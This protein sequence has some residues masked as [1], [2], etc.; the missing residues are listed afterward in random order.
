MRPLYPL[1]CLLMAFSRPAL[2]Q[3]KNPD[4][5]T[6]LT[7]ADADTLDAAWQYDTGSAEAILN[8]YEPLFWFKGSS[9]TKLVPLLAS[10]VP[11]RANGLIS[12]DG[13][14]YT[15]PI[16]KAVHFQDGSLMT[17][18][19]VRYSL[20]RFML[21]DR[22]GGPASLL[23]QPLVGYNS[24]RDASG[25]LKPNAYRDAARAVQVKGDAVVLRLPKPYAPLLSILAQWGLV[26]SRS[27]AAQHGDW[28]G[29]EATWQKFNN[30]EKQA[31]AFYEQADGTG[32]FKLERWDRANHEIVLERFDD[33]WRG[34][35]KLKRAIIKSVPEFGTRKLLL[36]AG[37]ADVIYASELQYKEVA[38]LP[39]VRIIE[40]QSSVEMNPVVYFT[41]KINPVGNP[42][43]GSGRL[44]GDGIPPDF[45]SDKNVRLGFA[46]SMASAGFIRDVLRGHG[47]QATGCIP[48]TLP[49]HNPRQKTFHLDLAAAKEHFQKAWDGKV[50]K[51]GFRFTI[52]YNQGNNEREVIAEILKRNVEGLN[53]K[54]HVDV[55]PVE[56]PQF[57]DG[58]NASKLPIFTMGWHAD[59][60]D[61]HDFAFPNMHSQGS[62]P[63][64]Q[65]YS[66]PKADRLI[67][68]AIASTKA[69]RRRKLYFELQRIEHE[70]CPHLLIVDAV[71][72][73]TQ[74]DW[75][76]GWTN[77][78][79]FPDDPYGSYFYQLWK[80]PAAKRERR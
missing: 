43:I 7:I 25:K 56:W 63:L 75:V 9:L 39:G 8:I 44:D 61:P 64:A 10:K 12:R 33:Y 71:H 31:T 55:R 38:G 36:Q 65:H 69:A 60:P 28:D 66:N 80:A 46:D 40:N 1:V 57:L 19:D 26:V 20:M 67:D 76:R 48:V 27:W 23:L 35:A 41:F 30:P 32:P 15:I 70:D 4:T 29:S 53:P 52:L 47:T 37:D 77:M 16:R 50:W 5:M 78:P 24:T 72:F 62:Y 45:F 79:I 3:V 22:D 11:S 59:Y 6:E 74:R 21:Q 2:A 73:R 13:R 68:E 42:Y 51:E 34:P 14:V 17:P 18:E 58:Y 49:G 54:F